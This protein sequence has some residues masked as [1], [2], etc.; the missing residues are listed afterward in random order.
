MPAEAT[1]TAYAAGFL[2]ATALLHGAGVALGFLIGRIGDNLGR[3]GYR[4]GGALVALTGVVLL[5]ATV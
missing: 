2:L 3:Q 1:A 5:A 4:L